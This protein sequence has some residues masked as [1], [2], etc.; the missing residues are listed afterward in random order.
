MTTNGAER[1]R[2]KFEGI[3]GVHEDLEAALK[4]LDGRGA[5]RDV[6]DEFFEDLWNSGTPI[7]ECVSDATY[8]KWR[9]HCYY[10]LEK[11]GVS[12]SSPEGWDEASEEA[13]ND[14][15]GFQTWIE[16]KFWDD[17]EFQDEL[18]QG[19][20]GDIVSE[21]WPIVGVFSRGL[22]AVIPL[23]EVAG[24]CPCCWDPISKEFGLRRG[25]RE[26][27][28]N[29]VCA[30][31]GLDEKASEAQM[32]YQRSFDVVPEWGGLTIQQLVAESRAAQGEPL[33][34]T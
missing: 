32:R 28:P 5:L 23:G 24:F 21:R 12:S 2:F 13:V 6:L 34:G 29:I 25:E 17:K 33:C 10:E 15:D 4:G 8:Q 31:C 1:P 11:Q 19:Y 22:E 18:L 7:E 9:T 3:H 27:E 16:E 14:M 26:P 30:K 20:T